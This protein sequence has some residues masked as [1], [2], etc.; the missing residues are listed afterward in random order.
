MTQCRTENPLFSSE[1][2]IQIRESTSRER[3]CESFAHPVF[4][5]LTC[6]QLRAKTQTS[7]SWKICYVKSGPPILY[8]V[9]QFSS[10]FSKDK[11][12][13]CRGRI[14]VQFQTNSSHMCCVEL[15][16]KGVLCICLSSR[17][18]LRYGFSLFTERMVMP[19]WWASIRVKLLSIAAPT[20][21]VWLCTY[22]RY[23]PGCG[24]VYVCPLV[25][26]CTFFHDNF[27]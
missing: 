23:W 20:R 21:L 22:V 19:C 25:Y 7:I 12:G 3:V 17:G 27:L 14:A 9:E 15:A 26:V 10:L 13:A 11:L 1:H 2:V 4:N 5:Q 8:V 6:A 18:P 24:L 16:L